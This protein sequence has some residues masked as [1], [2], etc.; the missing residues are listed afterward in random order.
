MNQEAEQRLK[1]KY[2]L[3]LELDSMIVKLEELLKLQS[4]NYEP[5]KEKYTKR[6]IRALL[7]IRGFTNLK[8][9]HKGD[10]K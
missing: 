5:S 2:E 6:A 3:E 7:D 8:S 1:R 4:L 9:F 10:P